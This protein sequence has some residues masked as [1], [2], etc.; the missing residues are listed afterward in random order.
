MISEKKEREDGS[1]S[2]SNSIAVSY[3]QPNDI[4]THVSRVYHKERFHAYQRA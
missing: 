1:S 3:D 2:C 4:D